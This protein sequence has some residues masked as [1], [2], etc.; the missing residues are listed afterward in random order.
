MTAYIIRRLIETVVIILIVSV[1]SFLLLHLM[2]GDPVVTMLGGSASPEQIERVRLEMRLDK[3]LHMQYW[4]WVSNAIHGD[5][6]RSIFF[7]APTAELYAKRMPVTLYL[8]GWA[9]LISAIVG[10]STGIICAIR[11]GGIADNLLTL[12]ANLGIAF[13]QFWL[14]IIGMYFLGLKLGWL[15]I[16][17]YTAPTVDF[18]RSTS[19]AI[20]PVFVL[21]V[22]N[23][24]VM[25]RQTRSSML[26]VV[27]QDYIRTAMAK[28]LRERVVVLKH[29]L[30]NALIP[31]VTLLGLRIRFLIGG[32]VL[33]ETVFNIPGMGRLIVEA[34]FNKDICVVQAGCLI[35]GIFVCL[36]NLLTDVSYGWLD[37]RIRYQ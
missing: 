35:M 1:I 21:G 19:Q 6:G 27:R 17:G 12:A 24:A 11:R 28:G 25:T 30:K 16:Q 31:I 26:E 29:A 34:G 3:P 18:W 5:F 36:T 15:P 9:L 20:M 2:P 7:N 13:P 33:V 14:G 23:L 32:S 8:D 4:Y 10:V 37:P 22:G